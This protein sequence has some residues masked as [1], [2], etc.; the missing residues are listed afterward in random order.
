M[1]NRIYGMYIYI[2]ILLNTPK[3]LT[4]YFWLKMFKFQLLDS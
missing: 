3:E 2:Y 4:K 1:I